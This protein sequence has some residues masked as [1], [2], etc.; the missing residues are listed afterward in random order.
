VPSTSRNA[1]DVVGLGLDDETAALVL[2]GN[3]LTVYAGLPGGSR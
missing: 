1:R 2:G 3:A